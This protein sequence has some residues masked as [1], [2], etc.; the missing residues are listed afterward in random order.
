MA[1]SGSKAARATARQRCPKSQW[2]RGAK[3]HLRADLCVRQRGNCNTMNSL[4]YFVFMEEEVE[5]S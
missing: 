4:D 1:C 3:G 2:T 5:F